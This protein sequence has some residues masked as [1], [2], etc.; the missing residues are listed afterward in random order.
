VKIVRK[1]AIVLAVLVL[2]PAV[3]SAQAGVWSF[4]SDLDLYLGLRA[5]AEYQ[6]SNEIG[7]RGTVGLCLISPTQVSSTLVGVWHI[8]PPDNGLQLDVE[9]GLI[10]CNFDFL[11]QYVYTV[12]SMQNP[13]IYFVPGLCASVGYR[14]PSGHQI[15]LRAGAGMTIGYDLGAWGNPSFLPDVTLEYSWRAM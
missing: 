12:P 11:N 10:L 5:G 14:W 7:I 6:F 3:L 8:M 13:F 4:Q 1:A 2:S 9:A 15:A